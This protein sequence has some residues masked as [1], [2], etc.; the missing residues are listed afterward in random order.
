[1]AGQCSLLEQQRY[2]QVLDVSLRFL[3]AFGFGR[4]FNGGGGGLGPLEV[5]RRAGVGAVVHLPHL[6]HQHH[7]LELQ[8]GAGTACHRPAALLGVQRPADLPTH[9]KAQ[10]WK[11][12]VMDPAQG[13]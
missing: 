1:M 8:P 10:V 3:L 13:G 7:G 12:L 9:H 6:V 4:H 11:I 2:I 5:L